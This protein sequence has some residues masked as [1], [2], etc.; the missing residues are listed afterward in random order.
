M[1]QNSKSI[2]NEIQERKMSEKEKFDFFWNTVFYISNT[3]KDLHRRF[4]F[5]ESWSKTVLHLL[6]GHFVFIYF[7]TKVEFN[8]EN[9]IALEKMLKWE[10]KKKWIIIIKKCFLVWGSF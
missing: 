1:E 10:V 5:E 4:F 7:P 8:C 2:L 6:I 3:Q 9:N